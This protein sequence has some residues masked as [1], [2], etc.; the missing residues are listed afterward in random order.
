MLGEAI[1]LLVL[2]NKGEIKTRYGE[3]ST[4]LKSVAASQHLRASNL[5]A[6]PPPH[7]PHTNDTL[8]TLQR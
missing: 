3:L 6:P 7:A 5:P 8:S 4:V 1:D 2:C